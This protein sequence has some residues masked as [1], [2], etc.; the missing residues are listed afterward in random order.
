M[1]IP[2]GLGPY[3]FRRKTEETRPMKADMDETVLVSRQSWQFHFLVDMVKVI[4]SICTLIWRVNNYVFRQ[5]K[6]VIRRNES[7]NI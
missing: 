4:F 5:R 6:G 2:D 3:I 7:T 1:S